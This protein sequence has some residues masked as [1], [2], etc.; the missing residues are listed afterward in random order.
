[1]SVDRQHLTAVF[2]SA[3]LFTNLSLKEQRRLAQSATTRWYP[4]GAT[5]IR[6]G[7]TSMA[8]YVIVSGRVAVEIRSDGKAPQPIREIGPYGFFGELGLID[9]RPRSASVIAVVPT[10]CALLTISDIRHNPRIA[11]G[12]LP[13]LAQ[14]V[15]EASARPTVDDGAW[16][17]ALEE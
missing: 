9:D 8:L 14:R 7:D 4:A 1:M 2:A 16:L 12:L 17:R 6:E 10:E 13:V 15:R 11:L 3:L 5:I